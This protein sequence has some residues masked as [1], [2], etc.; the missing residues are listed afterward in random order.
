MHRSMAM[1]KLAANTSTM[2]RALFPHDSRYAA[3]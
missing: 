1:P 3:K 2:R